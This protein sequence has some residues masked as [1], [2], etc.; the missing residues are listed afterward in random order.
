MADQQFDH[1]KLKYQSVINSMQ[2]QGVR[3]QNLNMQGDKLYIRAEAPSE[4]AKNRVWDQVK[5][6]D[7][8][9]SDV[10]CDI[11]VAAGAQQQAQ[12]ARVQTA[13]AGGATQEIYTVQSGDT[14]SKI[15]EEYYGDAAQYM[16]IFNANRDKL[17]DPNMI[18]PGQ[19]LTIPLD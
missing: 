12:G 2:Q 10:I 5:M 6:V 13:A 8:S 19:Q 14:L 7:A 1:L 18:K 16:R 9:Y 15:A 11:T 4:E 3:L 17:N